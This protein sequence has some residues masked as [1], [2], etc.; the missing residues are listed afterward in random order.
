MSTLKT[1][2]IQDTSG[3]N[4]STPA[5]ISNGR[6]KAWVNFDGTT[7]TQG[8]ND[9][10][11]RSSFN[12]SSITDN[13]TGDYTVTFSSAMADTNYSVV[14]TAC[15]VETGGST[16]RII[17]SPRTKATGSQRMSCNGVSSSS[18]FDCVQVNMLIFG[19]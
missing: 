6:A 9:V 19:D 11:I 10:T 5:Q 3:N 14:L 7:G 15:D 13:G 16:S 17:A 12:V 2:N 4:N 8:Q 18:H 1:S